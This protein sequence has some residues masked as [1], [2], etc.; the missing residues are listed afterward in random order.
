MDQSRKLLIGFLVFALLIG[1]AAAGLARGLAGSLAFAAAAFLGAL[2][3]IAGRQC[4]N[5]RH[6]D[7][8]PFADSV[9]CDNVPY[10][11]RNVKENSSPH[12][13]HIPTRTNCRPRIN[14]GGGLFL[15]YNRISRTGLPSVSGMSKPRAAATVGAMSA[16][17][18][19]STI[20]PGRMSDPKAIRAGW[21]PLSG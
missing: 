6:I 7:N 4:L 12:S 18:A 1:D 3:Q 5:M 11:R 19:C 2:A 14:P 13:D 15:F 16:M 20:A 17:R 8:P 9:H 10:W 21:G